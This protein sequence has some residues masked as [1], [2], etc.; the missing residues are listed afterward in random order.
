[1]CVKIQRKRI[2]LQKCRLVIYQLKK[3]KEKVISENERNQYC[4]Y[5]IKCEV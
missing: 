4:S 3:E 1:M 5:L 2:C